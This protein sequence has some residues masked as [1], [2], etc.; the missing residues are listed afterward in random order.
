MCAAPTRSRSLFLSLPRD[1]VSTVPV[2]EPETILG[3]FLRPIELMSDG[4]IKCLKVDMH[5]FIPAGEWRWSWLRG[6][7][8]DCIWGR[9][10][11][12]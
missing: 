10:A 6:G 5:G 9:D 4:T 12:R 1:A 2:Y 11:A 3:Y 8:E 7:Q